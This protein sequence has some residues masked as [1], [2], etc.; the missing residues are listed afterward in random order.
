MRIFLVVILLCLISGA[1]V[2]ADNH[3]TIPDISEIGNLIPENTG[4]FIFGIGG[5]AAL[6]IP[7]VIGIL[8]KYIKLPKGICPVVAFVVG[9]VFGVIVHYLKLAPDLTL[10]QAALAGAAIGGTSTGLYD[11]KKRLAV[12]LNKS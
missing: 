2:L 4:N 8:K 12:L 11:M 9:I 7:I 5:I 1:V 3:I 6:V 10:L